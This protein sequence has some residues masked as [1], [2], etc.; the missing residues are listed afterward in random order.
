M[1]IIHNP[2]AIYSLSADTVLLRVDRRTLAK[3]LWKAVAEDGTEFG[4]ELE[5]ALRHGDRFH[6]SRNVLYRIEQEPEFLLRIELSP[7]PGSSAMLG[8]QIGNL[9]CPVQV[10]D[11]F[12][13]VADEPGMREQLN[14][15]RLL[16]SPLPGIFEPFRSPAAHGGGHTHHSEHASFTT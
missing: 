6:V 2:L 15:M 11:G 10:R 3:R 13:F 1:E 14:R 9:H 12:L 16:F 5:H 7:S 8:W 4:F